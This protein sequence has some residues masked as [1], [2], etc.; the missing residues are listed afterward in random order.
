[1]L[2][3]ALAMGAALVAGSIAVR[4]TQALA[5]DG[6]E[7][8]ASGHAG[9]GRGAF[10]D[11]LNVECVAASGA[12]ERHNCLTLDKNTVLPIEGGW[13]LLEADNMLKNEIIEVSGDV[14]FV[15]SGPVDLGFGRIHV[16]KDAVLT[17][18]YEAGTE[19]TT[20]LTGLNNRGVIE[21]E[22]TVI[23]G[24]FPVGYDDGIRNV[25]MC[26]GNDEE[27][28]PVDL[29]GTRDLATQGS[30]LEAGT[31]VLSADK[32]FNDRLRL[33]GDVTIILREG[34]TL[35][36]LRGIH[37]PADKTFT[38]D[39]EVGKMPTL[40]A[41][42][43][44]YEG[45]AGIGGSTTQEGGGTV[46]IYGTRVFAKGGLCAAGIGAANSDHGDG[47]YTAGN[48]TICGSY[49]EA[50]GN[51]G[52]AGIGGCREVNGGKVVIKRSTVK[53]W[54][55]EAGA[56]GIGGGHMASAGPVEIIGSTVEATGGRHS[57]GIGGGGS[58]LL[59]AEAGN[60]GTVK[61]V[62]SKVT[63]TGKGRAAGIGGG[64]DE[65]GTAFVGA[66]NGGD[67]TISGDSVVDA[68]AGSGAAIGRGEGADGVGSVNLSANLRVVDFDNGGVIA[69]F[70]LRGEF[71]KYRNHVKVEPGESRK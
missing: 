35:Y 21:S 31:Y 52:A 27:S 42:S 14:S 49:V 39:G 53:A 4:P 38:V 9:R 28:H 59:T 26:V 16:N 40:A 44:A 43:G 5:D 47:G 57:A 45:N 60:G 41:G 12:H 36:C 58:G 69:P 17:L 66:G 67:V 54:G 13:W 65:E 33:A 51:D 61:I 62:D 25:V 23:E 63:A 20:S 29:A 19:G 70:D 1:M 15:C 22:G 18:Y 8:A 64:G 11:E 7:V 56:A 32:V 2:S 6:A 3:L 30:T 46:N 50:T 48:V 37:V 24:G 71:C 55:G 34:V 10:E 68:T